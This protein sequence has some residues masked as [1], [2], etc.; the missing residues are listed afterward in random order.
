MKIGLFLYLLATLYTANAGAQSALGKT[1]YSALAETKDIQS[2]S[3]HF[4]AESTKIDSTATTNKASLLLIETVKQFVFSRLEYKLKGEFYQHWNTEEKPYLY[5]YTSLADKI[6]VPEGMSSFLYC[7]TDENLVKTKEKEQLLKGYHTFCYKTNANSATQLNKRFLSYPKEVIVFIVFHELMHNYLQQLSIQIPYEYNEAL[8]D[9][10]GNYGALQFAAELNREL[11]PAAK[12]QRKR[13][14]KIY[15]RLNK[16]IGRINHKKGNINKRNT[17]CSKSVHK[18][19]VH[20]SSFQKDRFDYPVNNAYLLKNEYYSKH[21]FL[22]RK[23]LKKQ[24]D[25]KSFWKII[26]N[27]PNQKADCE[28]YLRKFC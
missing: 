24:K 26:I 25:L 3:I 6:S 11:L 7:G 1:A 18:L 12:K 15:H 13:N 8:C 9:V 16:T 19:L 20:G 5:L 14:E 17:R 2:E 22:I 21:Y 4:P 23:V 27:M 10:I 28:P